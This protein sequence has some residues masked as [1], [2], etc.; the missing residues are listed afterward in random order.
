MDNQKRKDTYVL[1]LSNSKKSWVDK[2]YY[3]MLKKLE[4][5]FNSKKKGDK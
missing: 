2:R 3:K 4:A 5:L 1:K